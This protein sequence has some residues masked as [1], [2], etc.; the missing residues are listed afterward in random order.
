MSYGFGAYRLE[1]APTITFSQGNPRP[2]APAI[3]S[4]SNARLASYNVE[5]YF[6]TTGTGRGAANATELTR[7]RAKIVAALA[8]LNA[9][10]I[11]LIE[12]E[13]ANGNA[14][15]TDLANG[16]N[17]L[18]GTPNDYKSVAD[19]STPNGTDLE[20]KNGMIYRSSTVTPFGTSFTDTSTAAMNG[21]YS[22][23]PLAQIF[24]LNSNGRAFTVIAHHGKSK[25]CTGAT[26]ADADQGDGQSC[27]NNRRLLQSQLLVNFVNNITTTTAD[28]LMV[29]DFNAYAEEDPIDA[30]RA[31]G[32][33]DVIAQF[34]P[35]SSKYSFTF[36]GQ[37]GQL[38]HG[39]A[40]SSLGARAT[41]ASIWHIDADEPPIIDYTT[42]NKPQDLYQPTPYRASDHDPIVM[43]FNLALPTAAG[44][45]LGGQVTTPDGQPLAGVVMRLAGAKQARAITDAQGNYKF[46]GLDAGSFY[47]V[48]PSHV[49]YSFLPAERSFSLSSNKTDATFTASPL[50]QQ[51]ANP[52]ETDMYFVRQQYLDF[53]GREP[54]A[55]GLAYWTSELNKCGTN[56]LCLNE[57]RIDISA[58][59]FVEEE[60]QQR[61]SFIYRIYRGALGRQLSYAE[62]NTDRQQLVSG[63]NLDQN[64]AS[65]ALQFV[66]RPEFAQRYSGKLTGE[67]FVDALITNI[68]QSEGVDLSGE[69]SQLLAKYN[70]GSSA[71]ESRSLALREAIENAS[72]RE[73]EYNPS[74]VLMEYFGYLRRDP[75]QDGYRFWLNVLNQTPGN[76]RG[77]VCS[78]LTS[79]EYQARFSGVISHSNRE[80]GK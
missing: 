45:E 20:I 29:G 64:K 9:D 63:D 5:N 56:A 58:A 78:F 26:G 44:T 11:G 4:G 25:S 42:A 69:R 40:T 55:G 27:F 76:Y 12:L 17:T 7:Q 8:G 30:L 80:C 67:S 49:N 13:K 75:E 50:P 77:M 48:A 51:T 60:M 52:L 23:D 10:V 24:K 54:D 70:G 79:A 19:L 57:R 6:L 43:S 72:F 15:A 18:L 41:G 32:M 21:A 22:R 62:F 61:G 2:A 14:A 36:Q 73:A 16:L 37:A 1:P 39:F 53:L 65:F 28:V 68:K 38:D 31:G 33:Q 47:T 71:S 35:T 74:F 59:F 34:V 46:A 66:Q 3:V